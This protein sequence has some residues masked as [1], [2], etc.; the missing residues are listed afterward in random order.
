MQFEKRFF[1]FTTIFQDNNPVSNCW[2]QSTD[3]RPQA[4]NDESLGNNI[5]MN[6]GYSER[7]SNGVE[8]FQLKT[9]QTAI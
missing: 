5:I 4:Y 6:A 8:G 1:N 7:E 3:R 9:A 2:E